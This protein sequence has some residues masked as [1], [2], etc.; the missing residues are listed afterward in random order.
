QRSGGHVVHRRTA[1]G[2]RR[3]GAAAGAGR[4]L[5]LPHGSGSTVRPAVVRRMASWAMVAFVAALGLWGALSWSLIP[6]GVAGRI[7]DVEH[8]SDTGYRFRVFELDSGR[9][10]VVDRQIDAKLRALPDDEYP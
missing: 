1:A 10:L 8:Y 6:A 5:P 3:G 9:S 2:G 4:G 7:V